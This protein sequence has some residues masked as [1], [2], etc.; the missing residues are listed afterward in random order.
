MTGGTS[1]ETKRDYGITPIASQ[2]GN[3]AQTTWQDPRQPPTEKHMSTTNTCMSMLTQQDGHSGQA[4]AEG[5]ATATDAHSP[6]EH[7]GDTHLA[8]R[9]LAHF[10]AEGIDNTTRRGAPVMLLNDC[11]AAQTL[12]Q[13]PTEMSVEGHKS[14]EK[15]ESTKENGSQA[16]HGHIYRENN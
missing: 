4:R 1:W 9:I 5:G 11:D 14:Q 13:R 2:R 3:R 10:F 16:K 12:R 15:H 7:P 8:L 6:K